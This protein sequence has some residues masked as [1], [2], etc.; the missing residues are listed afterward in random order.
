MTV[1]LPLTRP[2]AEDLAEVEEK[3]DHHDAAEHPEQACRRT[4]SPIC[5]VARSSSRP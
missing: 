4:G 1:K 2:T 5:I 3:D